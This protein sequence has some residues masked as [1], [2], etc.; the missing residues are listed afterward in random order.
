[1]PSSIVEVQVETL[2]QCHNRMLQCRTTTA[3]SVHRQSLNSTRSTPATG[4]LMVPSRRNV[5]PK[6]PRTYT[7]A[8]S[9]L[10]PNH[11]RCLMTTARGFT[12]SRSNSRHS[13]R[14]KGMLTRLAMRHPTRTRNCRA[15]RH[16]PLGSTH[17]RRHR[18]HSRHLGNLHI[19]NRELRR[20]HTRNSN[21]RIWIPPRHRTLHT[22]TR[23]GAD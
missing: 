5:Q 14:L 11:V 9:H 15:L 13:V 10:P 12:M 7:A 22:L 8:C 2:F 4:T 21:N 23:S 6:V 1:M 17:L 20:A 19:N 3:L 18:T 16:P